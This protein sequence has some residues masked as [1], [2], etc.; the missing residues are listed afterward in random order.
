MKQYYLLILATCINLN[1]NA[2]L[3]PTPQPLGNFE[4]I[5][6]SKYEVRY[7][8]RFK[9]HN[10]DKEYLEDTRVLQIGD[11]LVKEYSDIIYHFDSLATENFRKGLPTSS[12]TNETLP[13]EIF[14]YHKRKGIKVKYRLM[15]NGGVLCY[16]DRYPSF[17]WKFSEDAPMEIMG[18][19]CGKATVNFAG[20]EYS[21]WYTTDIP[22]PYGPYKF[23]GLPGLILRVEESN[24]M[25][26]WE[27]FSVV[28]SSAPINIYTY[29]K[30]IKCNRQD[31]NKTIG[32]MMR[33]PLTFLSSSGTKIMVARSDGSFGAPSNNEQENLYE[34]IEL[35]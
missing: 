6:A 5:E 31:A 4:T 9:K 27:V 13:C 32:R 33:K 20:R 15:L 28:K 12:N 23:Y 22:L 29:E 34:P 30:E 10:T 8:F 18:Y 3:A 24:G 11:G 25:Y 17:D 7:S 2:E 14:N 19:S 26:I 21:V 16:D 35:E 1:A